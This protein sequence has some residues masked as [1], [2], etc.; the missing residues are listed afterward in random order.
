[1]NF[2]QG[3][4][5]LSRRRG[6]E[7]PRHQEYRHKVVKH[8]HIELRKKHHT[9]AVKANEIQQQRQRQIKNAEGQAEPPPLFKNQLAESKQRKKTGQQGVCGKRHS[10][11]RAG[12]RPHFYRN[13]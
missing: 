6:N 10:K 1:M 13:G 5:E 7:I 12:R 3:G 11:D 4:R 9:Q 8:Q 2:R